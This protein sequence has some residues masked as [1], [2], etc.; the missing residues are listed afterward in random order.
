MKVIVVGLDHALQREHPEE[1][2]EVKTTR[3]RL[4][5]AMERLVREQRATLIAEEAGNDREAAANLQRELDE[6]HSF[7]GLKPPRVR[8]QPTSAAD[9]A[10]QSESCRQVDIR[11][12]GPKANDA[13]YEQAMVCKTLAEANEKE[14]V[15]VICGE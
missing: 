6:F 5:S 7:G 14:V 13:A 10:R 12:P 9:I 8:E 15:L 2:V 3:T 4:R 11:P 1:K